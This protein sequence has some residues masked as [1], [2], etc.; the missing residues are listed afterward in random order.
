MDI[1]CNWILNKKKEHWERGKR[2][3]QTTVCDIL[4]NINL[5]KYHRHIQCTNLLLLAI[6]VSLTLTV[7]GQSGSNVTVPLVS[8]ALVS[9][10][11]LIV[12]CGLT[13]LLG[14]IS[15]LKIWVTLTSTFQ[16]Y[17]ISN[18][19]I[20]FTKFRTSTTQYMNDLNFDPSRS[21]KLNSNGDIRL[22]IYGFLLMFNTNIG[23]N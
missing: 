4:I 5:S 20:P 1:F 16:V 10:K 15:G 18:L 9:Y 19:T 12:T 2:R 21:L 8:P 13:Q 14:E 17:S 11:Y 3:Q 22:P 7:Q 23:P 6:W